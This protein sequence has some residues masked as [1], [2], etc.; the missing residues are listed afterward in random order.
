[1]RHLFLTV[2]LIGMASQVT[3]RDFAAGELWSYQT[4]P[5]ETSSLV[6]ID[7]VEEVPKLGAVYHISVL[8][9]H[10]PSWKDSS[11]PETDLPHFPVLKETLEKSLVARVGNRQPLEGYRRGYDTW[12][13]AFDACK[14][15]AFTISVAEIIDVVEQ[16]IAKNRPT[17]SN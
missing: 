6:L 17:S 16:T 5:G 14:A 9:V 2:F 8:K 7:L 10:L 4:R 3:A 11:R 13:S 15:G 12:R 1:M